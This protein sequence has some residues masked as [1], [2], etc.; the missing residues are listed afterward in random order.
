M[1]GAI[2]NY[3]TEV[4]VSRS[5]AH[6]QLILQEGGASA[7]LLEFNGAKEVSAVNF[8]LR[9]EAFG[10]V[11][12][13]LPANVEGV[14]LALNAAVDA[15]KPAGGR[16]RRLPLSLKNNKEQAARVAWRIVKDWL[17]AQIAINAAGNAKLE[18]AL[19]GFAVDTRSGKTLFE[20]ATERGH[21]LLH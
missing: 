2:L 18:Q 3:T 9:T 13:R 1:S 11:S 14:I 7:V 17:E 20:A 12:F 21:F 10:E 15:D 16:R 19:L 4:P 5:L 6:I 8:R